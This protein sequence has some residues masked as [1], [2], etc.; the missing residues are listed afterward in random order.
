MIHSK[1]GRLLTEILRV[2][3][4]L[5]CDGLGSNYQCSNRR[6]PGGIDVALVMDVT[7]RLI[8]GRYVGAVVAARLVPRLGCSCCCAEGLSQLW[9]V[10][11]GD[12]MLLCLDEIVVKWM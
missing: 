7:A 1:H 11:I 10:M 3:G 5:S 9:R 6:L 2:K 8:R 4:C 12:D